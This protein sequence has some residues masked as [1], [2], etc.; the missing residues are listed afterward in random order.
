MVQETDSS[1]ET[2]ARKMNA[3]YFGH[4]RGE[5]LAYVPRESRRILEVGCGDG[6]SLGL[7]K[8]WLD[9]PE[10]LWLAG[11]E[12]ND[13]I[14][15]KASKVANQIWVGNVETLS[16]FEEIEASSLDVILCLDVLEHLVDPWDM[17]RKLTPLLKPNGRLIASI[18]NIRHWKFI[19]NLLFRADFNYRDA[20]LL[21]RTHL[22]FFVKKTAIE[23]ITCGG[24]RLVDA[25]PTREFKPVDMRWLL[26]KI[27]GNRIEELLVKQYLY[28]AQAI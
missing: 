17:V 26:Q 10:G 9:S 5:V 16:F 18:P 7:V 6:A 27:T 22:R 19:R 2:G 13:E 21:D 14:A 25:A 4:S 23:L 24:L 28:V 15:E 12:I 1:R 11:V 8:E 3:D 20:G